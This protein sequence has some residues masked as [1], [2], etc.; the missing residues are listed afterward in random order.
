MRKR[1]CKNIFDNIMWYTIYLLPIILTILFTAGAFQGDWFPFWYEADG[2]NA[3]LPFFEVLKN[4]IEFGIDL[5][6]YNIVTI[7]FNNLFGSDGLIPVF[8]YNGAII[9]YM[10]YFV[11][12]YLFHLMVDFLLFIPRL[13]HKWIDSFTRSES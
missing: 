12:V 13:A 3:N 9:L 10:S 2:D 6:T 7:T 11:W 1:T 8:E 5:D 4:F